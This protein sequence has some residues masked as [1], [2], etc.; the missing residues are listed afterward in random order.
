MYSLQLSGAPPPLAV[1]VAAGSANVVIMIESKL[2]KK[3]LFGEVRY[4]LSADGPRIVRDA[5]TAR[6]WVRWL[7]RWLLR[8]ETRTLVALDGI[9]GVPAVLASAGNRLERSYLSGEP[10]HKARPADPAYFR[11]AFRLLRRL[12]AADVVHNDLAK[13]PNLLVTSSGHPAFIDFQLAWHSRGRG[14]L[15]RALGHDDI[16]HLLKHKRTYCADH[17]TEREKKI[18]A[19]PSAPSRYWMRIVKPPYLFITRRLLGWSDREGASDR[20]AQR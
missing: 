20:G 14:R 13:E 10:M 5:S 11:A 2:L 3:D 16:R 15:F 7:A 12:H 18:L 19:S 4:E 9:D 8:R 6:L 17:L 1:N